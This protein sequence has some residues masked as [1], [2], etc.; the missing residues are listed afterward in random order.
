MDELVIGMD[1]CD[2]YTKVCCGEEEQSWTVPTVICKK[3][4]TDEWYVGKEAYGLVLTGT[5]IMVDK[6]ISW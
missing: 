5:G 3:K 2:T 4:Q 1:L 6:L